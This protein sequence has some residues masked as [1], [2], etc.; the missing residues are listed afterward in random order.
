MNI[1]RAILAILFFIVIDNKLKL[2][3]VIIIGKN[4]LFF[5]LIFKINS[6]FLKA[7]YISERNLQ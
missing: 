4:D 3:S 2:C 1:V 6:L 5:L 7:Q